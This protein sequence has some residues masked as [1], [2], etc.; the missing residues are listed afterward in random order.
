MHLTEEE[1]QALSGRRGE[2]L[3]LAMTIVVEL[4]RLYGA[5]R[6]IP[7]SQAHIDGCLYSAVGEAGADFAAKLAGLGA[8]VAVPTTLNITARDVLNWREFRIPVEHAENSRRVE[9]AYLQM[10]CIPTWT[11][12][13]YQYGIVPRCG[14][15][16]AWAESNAICY[17]NSVLGARTNR[18]GDLIDIC[19]AVTGKVPEFGLHLD[20]N[21]AGEVLVAFDV[22]GDAFDDDSLYA[23]AGY[24][25][26]EVA[27]SRVPVVTGIPG[28]A[29]KDNLKAFCAAA[30]S[31]GPI[32]LL[33]IPGLTPEAPTLEAVF[34]G[35]A[36]HE[37]VRVGPADLL[38]VADRLDAS[39]APT[40]PGKVISRPGKVISRPDEARFGSGKACVV[41]L[42]V[43]GCPHA[44][45]TELE[46]VARLLC[47]RRVR[48][49]TEFWVLTNRTVAGL[50]SRSGLGAALREAGVRL[51]CDT[52][53]LQ[54]PLD[55]WRIGSIVTNS[56][57][58]A[59]YAPSMIGCR[60]YL[61]GTATCVEAALAGEV[62]ARG[63]R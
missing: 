56:G 61:R 33:H 55:A 62:T 9:D 53:I 32:G 16:I 31:S 36:P 11:C 14:D 48:E 18:Y 26:G 25:A 34:G 19:C 29:T 50:A 46:R 40:G 20:E 12:A 54:F 21:R 45:Y 39:P 30:A 60:T 1:E 49:G 58:M 15:N 41:D 4:G 52:C 35:R 38:A 7:I 51:C 23:A 44:S 24:L 27:G 28:R 37:E 5:R 47:G 13:P 2:A 42:V 3:R 6:L 8:R 63:Q 17:A 57:K 10:G 59:H 43:V 22:P